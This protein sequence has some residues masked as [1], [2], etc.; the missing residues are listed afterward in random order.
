MIEYK[1]NYK[2]LYI[3][4][5]GTS[6]FCPVCDKWR[7]HKKERLKHP[8]WKISYF[9]TCVDNYVR[10]RLASLAI[11][12]RGHRLCGYQFTVSG[13]ASW[14]QMKHEYQYVHQVPKLLGAAGTDVANASN[15]NE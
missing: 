12:L 5:R 2:T 13:N 9:P 15:L 11:S 8:A 1:S 6:T 4:P 10:D 7:I 14:Q 3:N